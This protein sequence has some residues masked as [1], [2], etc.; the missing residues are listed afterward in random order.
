MC[1]HGSLAK[2]PTSRHSLRSPA[3]RTHLR[4]ASRRRSSSLPRTKAERRPRHLA[5]LPLRP[6]SR[7]AARNTSTPSSSKTRRRQRSS[8]TRSRPDFS[9]Q[10]SSARPRSRSK[11]SFYPLW[12][13]TPVYSIV[14]PRFHDVRS[15]H[16]HIL[17]DYVQQNSNAS[18]KSKRNA[19]WIAAD[20]QLD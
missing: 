19:P 16:L 15:V 20:G 1:T 4:H 18:I 12:L 14:T 6:S 10:R 8:R 3:E 5:R 2:S 13:F 11:V 17:Y 9:R 7:S